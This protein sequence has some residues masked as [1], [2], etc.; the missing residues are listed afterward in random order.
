MKILEINKF[1][2][3]KGGADK[4]FLDVVALLE[5]AGHEVAVFS[6]KH[7][8]NKKSRWEK[9]FVST[10]GYTSE[11]SL[12]E[13]IKGIFRMFFSLEA[14]RKINKLLDDFNPDVVHIHNIYHQLSPMILFEIKK[15]GIPIVMTVHDYKLVNPNYNLYHNG[16][17]YNRCQNERYY[18]CLLDRCVKNSRAK[19]FLAMLEMYWHDILGTYRKNI[20]LYICPSEFMKNI[21]VKRGLNEKKV[22][23]VPHFILSDKNE[24]QEDEN[25]PREKYALYFGR[26]SKSKG[27]EN[28]IEIF[29]DIPEM[30]L[31]LAGNPASE[32]NQSNQVRLKQKCFFS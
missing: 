13:K 21:L 23:V 4:H 26:I 1:Y 12:A 9:Y 16:K 28:L 14:K 32:E 20:D 29:K 3:P 27:V 8:K 30:K 10:V 15:R 17:F 25:S 11:Y 6:M 24:N 5:S 18:Q 22:K 7:L 19:S 31:Y 2:F